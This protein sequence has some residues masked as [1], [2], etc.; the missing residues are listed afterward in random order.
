MP[1]QENQN[2]GVLEDLP[3][4]PNTQESF[5]EAFGQKQLKGNLPAAELVSAVDTEPAQYDPALAQY[6]EMIKTRGENGRLLGQVKEVEIQGE[7]FIFGHPG[8]KEAMGTAASA[9]DGVALVYNTPYVSKLLKQVV[10]YPKEIS[11][12]GLD[13]FDEHPKLFVEVVVEADKFLNKYL[14]SE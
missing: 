13:Y 10:R 9:L 12:K 4:Y 6:R 14:G 2:F 3:T 5:T 1:T 8:L 7:T 11:V